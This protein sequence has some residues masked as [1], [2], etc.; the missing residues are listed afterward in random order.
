MANTNHESHFPQST[1]VDQ[2]GKKYTY[3]EAA[4]LLGLNYHYF[5][6]RLKNWRRRGVFHLSIEFLRA[7]GR[8]GRP[9][10]GARLEAL[11]LL[12]PAA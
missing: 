4:E 8:A 12:P 1:I 6:K 10:N 9:T 3:I 11:A 5:L 7:Y 2:A